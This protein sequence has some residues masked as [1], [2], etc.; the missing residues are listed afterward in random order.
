MLGVGLAPIGTSLA[1][2]GESDD[3][4]QVP[5]GM[6]SM[7]REID[8]VI[9]D[10]HVDTETLHLSQ[11]TSVR[12]RVMIRLGTLRRSS[13]SLPELGVAMPPKMDQHFVP[14]VVSAVYEALRQEIEIEKIVRIES[15]DVQRGNRRASV[16]VRYID[17]TTGQ[18]EKATV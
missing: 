13:T 8:P 16:H 7:C 4:P 5:D 1:G 9:R 15:V 14:K 17:L 11:T 18:R 3:D 2:I 6:S 12:Q 10:Y